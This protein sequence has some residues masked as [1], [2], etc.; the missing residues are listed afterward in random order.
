VGIDTPRPALE[1]S[2]ISEKISQYWRVS[3]VEVTGSTQDDL[4]AQISRN[5]VQ[6]GEVLVTDFQSAGRGRLDRNFEAPKSSA[7]LFSI[8]I[9]PQREKSEWSF[10]P[11]LAGVVSTLALSELDPSVSSQLKWPNDILI[12]DKKVGGIIA[13]LTSDGVILGIGINVGMNSAE[14]PVEHATSLGIEGFAVLDRNLLLSTFLNVFEEL[15][16]RWEDGEDLRHLYLERSATLGRK[17]KAVLPGVDTR[18]GLAKD[19]SVTGELILEDGQRVTVGDIV[20]L[21]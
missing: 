6:S 14:L 9:K 5:E 21:R 18:T 8:Y 7:L 13:Q 20:H 3:V 17:I 4:A 2:V 16:L 10:L 1:K 12:A 11:I 19:I 15:L